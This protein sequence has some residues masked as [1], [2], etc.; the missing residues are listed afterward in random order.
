MK[1][2]T[3]LALLIT[4]PLLLAAIAADIFWESDV[5]MDYAVAPIKLGTQTVYVK[6]RDCGAIC[7][8]WLWISKNPDRCVREDVNSDYIGPESDESVAYTVTNSSLMLV[9]DPRGWKLPSTGDWLHLQFIPDFGHAADAYPV[10]HIYFGSG[11]LSVRA[12]PGV[13]VELRPCIR[14]LGHTWN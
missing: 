8:G 12:S 11:G 6:A 10:D 1:R 3:L 9:D 2:R 5:T 14:F 4:I 13:A 7:S